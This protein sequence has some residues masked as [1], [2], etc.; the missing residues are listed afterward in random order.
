MWQNTYGDEDLIQNWLDT[1]ALN[2]YVRYWIN[3]ML[4]SRYG[5]EDA[6][7]TLNVRIAIDTQDQ[8]VGY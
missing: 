8:W 3:T 4:L 6:I 7:Q 2:R 5:Y 1:E